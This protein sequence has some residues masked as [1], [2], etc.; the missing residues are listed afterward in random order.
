MFSKHSLH[1]LRDYRRLQ[2]IKRDK[3]E[4][5]A[6]VHFFL[7]LYD[8]DSRHLVAANPLDIVWMMR[9]SVGLK[10]PRCVHLQK[11]LLLTEHLVQLAC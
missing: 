4:I 7:H 6:T 5:S 11:Y 2:D 3:D 9:H 10:V 1:S 8:F